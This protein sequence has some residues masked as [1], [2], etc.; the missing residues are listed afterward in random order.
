MFCSFASVLFSSLLEIRLRPP[1]DHVLG[2][3]VGDHGRVHAH[4]GRPEGYTKEHV[5]VYNVSL[6]LLTRAFPDRPHFRVF[7]IPVDATESAPAALH[8]GR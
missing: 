1:D 7:Q 6:P 4:R 5:P 3:A 8:G 2:E